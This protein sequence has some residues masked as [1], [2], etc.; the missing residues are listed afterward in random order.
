MFSHAGKCCVLQDAVLIVRLLPL[1]H[2]DLGGICTRDSQ[3]VFPHDSVT[4]TFPW[5]L[6]RRVEDCVCKCQDNLA[7]VIR[8]EEVG[9]V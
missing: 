6:E 5:N 1:V 7:V 2:V 8:D 3:S 4:H 9:E